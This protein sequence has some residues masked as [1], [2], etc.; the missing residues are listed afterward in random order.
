[1]DSLT[2]TDLPNLILISKGC[3]VHDIYS[4]S[5]P[6]KL[7]FV[8]TDRISTYNVILKNG[9]LGKGKLLTEVSLFWFQKLEH[10]ILNHFV[11]ANIDEMP[12][13]IC[14]YHRQLDGGSMVIKKVKVVPLEAIVWGHLTGSAWAEYKKSGTVHRISLPAGLMEPEKLPTPL[15]TPSTKAEQGSHDENILPEQA[16]KLN[17][18]ELNARISEAALALYS[19]VSAHVHSKGWILANTKFEFGLFL[20]SPAPGAKQELLLIDELHA[21]LIAVLATRGI[22]S[23][24]LTAIFDKQYLRDWLVG[25]GFRKGLEAGPEGSGGAG[26][27]ID[28]EIIEGTRKPYEVV[29]MLTG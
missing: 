6:Y 27:V 9:I 12:T 3:K 19:T 15:F 10:I 29:V 1:M 20:V 22:C 11:M 16:S 13:E 24:T 2:E 21:G 7:L 17:G 4:T 18:S 23:W 26:W 28:D 25:S 8:A 5:D 14:G